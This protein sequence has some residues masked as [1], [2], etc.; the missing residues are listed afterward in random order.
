MNNRQRR[1]V[2]TEPTEIDALIAEARKVLFSES[3]LGYEESEE[4]DL[5]LRLIVALESV[6]AELRQE[7]ERAD[8]WKSRRN[9]ALEEEARLRADLA[10]ARE[11]IEK[12]RV[13]LVA[14]T[15]KQVVEGVLRAVA[16]H[17]D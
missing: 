9:E 15:E 5:I 11:V 13:S 12:V 2:M 7:R 16:K 4:G 1:A 17:E 10:R 3:A 8:E 6:Q 14:Q